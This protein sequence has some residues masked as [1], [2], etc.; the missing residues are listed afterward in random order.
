MI[1]DFGSRLDFILSDIARL[2]G[3]RFDRLAREQLGLSRAQC[4]LLVVLA[5]GTEDGAL[6]QA[7]LAD[8]MDM[9][10]MS[11]AKLC[12]RMQ[13]GGW[14]VR[15][16][17]GSDRRANLV[18]LAPDAGKALMRALRIADQLQDDALAGFNEAERSQLR[19]LLLRMHANVGSRTGGNTVSPPSARTG[20]ARRRKAAARPSRPTRSNQST[21]YKDAR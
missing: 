15:E 1:A 8:E 9:T 20:A 10:P 19:S 14:I 7:A 18:K 16:T 12:A 11:V 5:M 3:R 17:S 2:N 6:N 21:S 13:A 4:R